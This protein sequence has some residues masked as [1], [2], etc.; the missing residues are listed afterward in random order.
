M[1]RAKSAGS[2][3]LFWNR[4]GVGVALALTLLSALGRVARAADE[5]SVDPRVRIRDVSGEETSQAPVCSGS[6]IRV[7]NPSG[8]QRNAA[9]QAREFALIEARDRCEMSQGGK[10]RR[11]FAFPERCMIFSSFDGGV[12]ECSVR[13]RVQCEIREEDPRSSDLLRIERSGDLGSPSSGSSPAGSAE[14]VASPA[15]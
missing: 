11:T 3:K 5:G 6:F 2:S 4:M 13:V 14:A 15:H 9:S 10:V 7:C 12:V 8:A 1:K